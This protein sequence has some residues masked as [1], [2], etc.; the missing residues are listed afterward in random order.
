MTSSITYGMVTLTI[1][2]V[3]SF[4]Q[5]LDIQ[6]VCKNT[7]F[8]LNK[9]CGKFYESVQDGRIVKDY[10]GL[11]IFLIFFVYEFALTVI[12]CLIYHCLSVSRKRINHSRFALM[13]Y[14]L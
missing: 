2:G 10:E 8:S 3:T 6:H 7:H 4:S 9:S 12:C 5:L 13:I 14:S 11:F 1:D